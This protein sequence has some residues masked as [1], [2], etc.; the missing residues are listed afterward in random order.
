MAV[1]EHARPVVKVDEGAEEVGLAVILAQLIQ[2]NLD[3]NPR[4]W[5]DFKKLSSRISLDAVDA[6]VSVTLSFDLNSL[7]VYEGIRGT[8]DIKISASSEGLLGLANLRIVAGLPS[9]FGREARGLRAGLLTGGVKIVGAL[10]KPA[11][12]VRFTRLMSVR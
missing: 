6:G 1:N 12:L 9:P 3:Q 5:D 4:K 11:Q 2:Q 8:P 7:V 10:R